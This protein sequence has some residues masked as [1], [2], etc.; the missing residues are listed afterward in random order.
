MDNLQY[1]VYD[2]ADVL[3][4]GGG[5]AGVCAALAA[6]RTGVSVILVERSADLGGQAAEIHTWG[7]DGFISCTGKQLIRG[8]PW[9][10]LKKPY[11][12]AVLIGCGL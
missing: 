12:R 2:S 10:I 3:V 1:T 5:F 9:E 11:Q 8:I 6:A 7:L 4:V